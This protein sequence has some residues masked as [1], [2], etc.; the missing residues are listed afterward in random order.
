MRLLP[1]STVNRGF[2]IYIREKYVCGDMLNDYVF[3]ITNATLISN[4]S[5]LNVEISM[6]LVDSSVFSKWLNFKNGRVFNRCAFNGQYE[7]DSIPR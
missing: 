4:G 1:R 7:C 3:V 6:V 5:I 2:I